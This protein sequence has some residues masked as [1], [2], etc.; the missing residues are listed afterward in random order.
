MAPVHSLTT[1]DFRIQRRHFAPTSA[2]LFPECPDDLSPEQAA[3]N[4]APVAGQRGSIS[5]HETTD[6]PPALRINGGIL[7][8]PQGSVRNDAANS[9]ER[10]QA[11]LVGIARLAASSPHAETKRRS[12]ER[13]EYFVLPV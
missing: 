8:R 12:A 10:A 6:C 1:R 7:N 4:L 3:G 13:P 2:G 5:D 9:S 11:R